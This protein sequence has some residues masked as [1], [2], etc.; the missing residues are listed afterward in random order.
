ME[1]QRTFNPWVLGSSPRRPTK[2]IIARTPGSALWLW[3]AVRTCARRF[4][5]GVGLWLRD[6]EDGND[7]AWSGDLD[8]GDQRFDEGFA[9]VVAARQDDFVDVVGDLA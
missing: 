7:P 6:A 3:V 9:L 2:L 5:R 1:V 4:R 8:L